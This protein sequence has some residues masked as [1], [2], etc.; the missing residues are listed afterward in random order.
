MFTGRQSSALVVLSVL[1]QRHA[2]VLEVLLDQVAVTEVARRYEVTRQTVHRW[3]LRA[4]AA[5]GLSGLEERS[6][7]PLSCPHQMDP[8]VEARIVELRGANEGWG[9][10]SIGHQLGV[11]GVDPVPGRSSIHRCLVRHGLI[12]PGR[13]RRKRSDCV[14]WERDRPMALWQMDIVGGVMLA[15]GS[16]ASIVSGF[17]DYSRFVISARVV[18]REIDDGEVEGARVGRGCSG[19]HVAATFRRSPCHGAPG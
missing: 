12:T 10:I 4:H 11:E 1:E 3:W 18:E 6:S 8:V 5:E 14:R 7:K 16:K 9:P 19:G 2:A 17:D 13:R 15:D